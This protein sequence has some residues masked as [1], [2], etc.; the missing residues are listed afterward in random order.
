LSYIPDKGPRAVIPAEA[1][2]HF[3]REG[4]SAGRQARLRT[5]GMTAG[6]VSRVTK[7]SCHVTY[8]GIKVF[9]REQQN[10]IR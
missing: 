1:G 7:P 5:S 4:M 8:P 2:S 10:M 9:V 6:Q 3:T